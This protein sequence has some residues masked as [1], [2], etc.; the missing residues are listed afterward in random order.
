VFD[1]DMNRI[2]VAIELAYRKDFPSNLHPFSDKWLA[3]FLSLKVGFAIKK[4]NKQ[5]I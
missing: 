4:L 3:K 5:P 1:Y 2:L